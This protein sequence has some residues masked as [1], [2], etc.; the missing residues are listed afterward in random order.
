MTFPGRLQFY[1]LVVQ[2]KFS[3]R[4]LDF[5]DDGYVGLNDANIFKATDFEN[6]NGTAIYNIAMDKN[7]DGTVNIDDQKIYAYGLYT[8]I[9]PNLPGGFD[10][11]IGRCDQ[12]IGYE[13]TY[14]CSPNGTVN[15]ASGRSDQVDVTGESLPL[16]ASDLNETCNNSIDDDGDGKIDCADADCNWI[17]NKIGAGVIAGELETPISYSIVDS[18]TRCDPSLPANSKTNLTFGGSNLVVT[19]LIAR[20]KLIEI[21]R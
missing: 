18:A 19:N 21:A 8:M 7:A 4:F 1:L 10:A 2:P 13:T 3:W 12:A 15:D 16:P 9:N 14:C 5:D 6:F 17:K 11:Q 20:Q